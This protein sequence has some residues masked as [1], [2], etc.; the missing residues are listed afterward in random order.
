MA[1]KAEQQKWCNERHAGVR[2]AQVNYA[3][4]VASVTKDGG[5]GRR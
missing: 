5:G 1:A 2:M 4:P 3:N